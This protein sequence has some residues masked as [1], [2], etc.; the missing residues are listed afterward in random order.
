MTTLPNTSTLV[1]A[2]E[3]SIELD[4]PICLDYFVASSNKECKIARD[5]PNGEKF[6][7]KNPEE[8]TSPLK[9]MF[10]ITS[11]DTKSDDFILETQNSIYIVNSNML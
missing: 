11:G 4:K 2:A 9:S 10:K 3:M 1:K 7:Y 5:G 8:Y 6:L